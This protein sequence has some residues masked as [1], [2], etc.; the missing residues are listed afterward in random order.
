MHEIFVTR[1]KE[2]INQSINQSSKLLLQEYILLGFNNAGDFLVVNFQVK[3]AF[4]RN[5]QI[6]NEKKYG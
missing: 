5:H 3:I 4:V 2:T 6:T 1:R